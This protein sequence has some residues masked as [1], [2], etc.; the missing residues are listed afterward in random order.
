MLWGRY[1][2]RLHMSVCVV[3][4]L[5]KTVV[6]SLSCSSMH[7]CNA[8]LLNAPTNVEQL[9]QRETKKKKQDI[10]MT[11]TLK[12]TL[13]V[14]MLWFLF[15]YFSHAFTEYLTVYDVAITIDMMSHT[16]LFFVGLWLPILCL[17]KNM[18]TIEYNQRWNDGQIYWA[19]RSNCLDGS[20]ITRGQYYKSTCS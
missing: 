9:C 4:A 7:S 2:N 3:N 11:W 1:V 8:Q 16:V 5:E 19:P 20:H 10:K 13:L 6:L 12:I 14:D 17:K 18:T 15:F